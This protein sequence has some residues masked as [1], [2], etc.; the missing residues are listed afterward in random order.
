MP[1]EGECWLCLSKHSPDAVV[2]HWCTC[3]CFATTKYIDHYVL[4][5]GTNTIP[6][7]YVHLMCQTRTSIDN[8][9]EHTLK[10]FRIKENED[11]FSE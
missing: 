7:Q 1:T 6:F 3:D 2:A 9:S 5:E 8:A 4:N 11:T 10:D